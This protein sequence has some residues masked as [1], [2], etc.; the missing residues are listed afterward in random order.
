MSR[1]QERFRKSTLCI[2]IA[3]STVLLAGCG[4]GAGTGTAA[5]GA[6]SSVR[7]SEDQPEAPSS[8]VV[9]S[10]RLPQRMMN[11]GIPIDVVATVSGETLTMNKSGDVYSLDI[12]LPL[13]REY[14]IFFAAQRNTDGLLLASAQ[15]TVS[16]DAN[17]VPMAIPQQLFNTNIDDDS[18]GFDNISEIERGSE[19]R[20]Q[21]A[22]FDGDGIPNES[23]SD[24]D[25]DGILDA[26]DA[27]PLDASE[28]VDTDGDGI[29][30]GRDRD[31]DNDQILDVDDKFPLDANESLDLDLDG[32]GNSVDLDDDGDGTID[33]EDPQPSNPNI[34]GNEDSD[35]DGFRDLEDKFPYNALEHADADGDGIGDEADTDDDN[36]GIPD[37]Q[38]NAI[39]GIPFSQ[40]IPTIDG[41]Y[42]WWE[43]SDAGRSDNKGNYLNI[44]HLMIDEKGLFVDGTGETDWN[45]LGNRSYWRAKHDGTNLYV[46]IV[47]KNEP[48]F[49]FFNDST[50]IWKDDTV[51]LY[52][53]IGN[54][55]N[56]SFVAND[57]QRIFRYE[58]NASDNILD[59]FN[60][61]TGMSTYYRTSRAMEMI[62]Q[63]QS[64]YEISVNMASIGLR[65]EERFG[66]DVQI[67]DDDDGGDRDAKWAWFAPSYQDESW[68]NPSL[69][70][71]A[72]LAPVRI[73]NGID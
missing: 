73:A 1:Y 3:A 72:V 4:A 66:M 52:F 47:V 16:T 57:Y 13:F 5:S 45:A 44:N 26:Y 67:N 24:D 49:E 48:F 68:N 54:D 50:D 21:T 61:A 15:T 27:F 7:A 53:D 23:D 41:A 17:V 28:G 37:I 40:R 32:I 10:V 8:T 62:N 43:W 6:D 64:I 65:P 30:D 25:N 39:V 58:H 14:A 20:L 70:G 2:A 19:P 59:G 11:L 33:L 71:T 18:D 29:G 22:D 9:L 35:N 51:E 46:L 42:G 55:K 69:F 36:N 12:A 60:A 38:D 34:T 31:D 56:T 63:T